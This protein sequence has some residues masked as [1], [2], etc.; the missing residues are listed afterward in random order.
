MKYTRIELMMVIHGA[1]EQYRVVMYLILS[2]VLECSL[3]DVLYG[4]AFHQMN[5]LLQDN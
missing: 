1:V 4:L 2:V 5:A 3:S